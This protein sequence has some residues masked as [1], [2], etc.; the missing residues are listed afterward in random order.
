MVL[1]KYRAFYKSIQ[2]LNKNKMK[3]FVSKGKEKLLGL[4]LA[5]LLKKYRIGLLVRNKIYSSEVHLIGL[6]VLLQNINNNKRKGILLDIGCFQ[7]ATSR[8]FAGNLK[9]IQ[10][11]GFEPNSESFK[12]A[13]QSLLTNLRFENMALSD[14]DGMTEFFKTDNGVSSSINTINNNSLFSVVAKEEVVMHKLDSYLKNNNIDDQAILAIKMDVQGHEL[15][16][17]KGAEAALEKTLFVVLEMSNHND[18]ENNAPYY[19]IDAHLRS[20]GFVLQNIF[21]NFTTGKLYEYDAIY[22]NSKLEKNYF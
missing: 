11:I 18:Y 22:I 17:L 3:S 20:K 4:Y 14:R 15:N 12:K 16:V 8:F 21:T 19:V 2:Q 9:D 13:Q 10:V 7:G 6:L 5:P 1:V